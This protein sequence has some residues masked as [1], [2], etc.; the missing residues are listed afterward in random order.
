MDWSWWMD[1]LVDGL[2][3]VED[4][5]GDDWLVDGME[6]VDGLELGDGWSGP[7]VL[8]VDGLEVDAVMTE[9]VPNEVL[10]FD[11]KLSAN[12][13]TDSTFACSVLA[14]FGLSGG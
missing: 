4:W 1:W 14:F 3:L 8:A 13:K 6:L 12:H 11:A 10:W 5:S 9:H 2:E 7:D